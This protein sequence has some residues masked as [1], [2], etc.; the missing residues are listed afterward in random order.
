M[1]PTYLSPTP[2]VT[3]IPS[4]TPTASATGTTATSIVPTAVYV[5]DTP[6]ISTAIATSVQ[7]E[8][9][10]L[11]T[12][13]PVTLLPTVRP[14]SA[15]ASPVSQ[16]V[17]RYNPQPGVNPLPI[18]AEIPVTSL[19][20]VPQNTSF[21][22]GSI[23]QGAQEIV[24]P[25]GWVAWWRTG[26]IS[27]AIYDELKTDGPCP[28]IEDGELTYRR[29]EFTVIPGTG[30][31][32]DPPRVLGTGQ[33][34][35]FFCTYGICVAGYLQ[36]VR[37]EAG[38]AYRLDAWVQ[39]WCSGNAGDPYHSQLDTQDDWRNCELAVGVDPAGGVDPLSPDIVWQAVT[40][41]D[42]FTYVST[43]SVLAQSGAMTLYLRGRS[44][45]GLQHNDF[46]FDQ[47]SFGP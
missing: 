39:A 42:A 31:W 36:Q 11:A 2:S 40:A 44:L 29:P 3:L 16:R 5:T 6:V 28:L 8:A 17:L 13:V 18:S 1:T 26:T 37:V 21:D 20:A 41:Y 9:V 34:A 38:Q 33:A 14:A 46:H 32:L 35:R 24:V 7:P 23:Q 25:Q 4:L 27:C 15:F 12:V 30:R 45:W 43:P 10:F 22:G 19:P 47:V